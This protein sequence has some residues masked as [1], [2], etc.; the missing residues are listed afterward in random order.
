[1]NGSVVSCRCRLTRTFDLYQCEVCR[2]IWLPPVKG[3][4]SPDVERLLAKA[5]DNL[6]YGLIGPATNEELGAW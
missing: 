2:I 1:V 5:R 3:R 4:L 6:A